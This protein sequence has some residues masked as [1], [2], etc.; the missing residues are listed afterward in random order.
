MEQN[1]SVEE[2]VYFVDVNANVK[3][4][5]IIPKSEYGNATPCQGCDILIKDKSGFISSGLRR[6]YFTDKEKALRTFIKKQSDTVNVCLNKYETEFE[7]LNKAADA[8]I[9]LTKNEC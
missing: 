8:V 3:E 6:N 5:T 4:Y 7:I 1:N 2:T 9:E